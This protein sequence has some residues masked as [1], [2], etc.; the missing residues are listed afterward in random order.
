MRVEPLTPVAGGVVDPADL[1]G[2]DRE[3][4]RLIQS[5]SDG[6]GYVVGDRRMGKTSL[7]RKAKATLEE[8]GHLV[9]YISA[10]TDSLDTFTSTLL[11]AVRS[12]ARLGRH[13]EKWTQHFEGQVR[14]GIA[15]QGLHLRGEIR[16]GRAEPE[17]DLLTLCSRAAREA[18]AASLV[19]IID[20]IAQL[21]FNLARSDPEAAAEFLRTLRR[22]RQSENRTAVVLA[23]SVGLHHA[24]P[25]GTALNDLPIIEV[26][27]LPHDDATFLGRR[28]LLGVFGEEDETRAA[29]LA[30]ATSGIPYYLNLLV[31][32][33]GTTHDELPD[34][35]ARAMV[36]E[37]LDG[38][39]WQTDHYYDRLAKYYP[40]DVPLAVEL[41][42]GLAR[43]R[44]SLDDLHQR[45]TSVFFEQPPS[46]ARVG[47]VLDRLR[48]DHYVGYQGGEFTFATPFLAQ[49]WLRMRWRLG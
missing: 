46:R 25:D 6:G 13:W 44:S 42:D 33:L 32:Q 39:R 19:L 36:D 49:A 3:L 4:S 23:G 20:E 16:R 1:V 30:E 24:V 41:L 15:G 35:N 2:R 40:D 8:A 31:Q 5:V 12:E 7:L 34:V 29:K 11:R 45:M 43:D 10:E 9:I 47:D 27:P 18:G 26:G 14:L 22:V 38:N 21:A 48:L 17:T 37:A 28:L